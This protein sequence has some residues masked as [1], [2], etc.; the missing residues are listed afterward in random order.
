MKVINISTFEELKLRRQPDRFQLYQARSAQTLSRCRSYA[1]G[2][3]VK[4]RKLTN[5]ANPCAAINNA[6]TVQPDATRTLLKGTDTNLCVL[7]WIPK[8]DLIVY[9]VRLKF[10]K[11]RKG[12]RSEADLS[13][14]DIPKVISPVRTRRVVLGQARE[15]P[16]LKS[17]NGMIHYQETFMLSGYSFFVFSSCYN[18]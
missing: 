6:D 3:S 15:K 11:L 18:A 10:K 13:D 14:A 4:F 2:F 12:I 5:E 9:D 7:G 16:G 17:F 1:C 8:E